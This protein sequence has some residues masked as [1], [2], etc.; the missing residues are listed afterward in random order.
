MF[1]ELKPDIYQCD[2]VLFVRPEL[3]KL[4]ERVLEKGFVKLLIQKSGSNRLP[5]QVWIEGAKSNPDKKEYGTAAVLLKYMNDRYDCRLFCRIF[6]IAIFCIQWNPS[7][8][9]TQ[10]KCLD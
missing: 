3:T 10:F 9:D 2:N 5:V 4:I 1:D 6:Y 8:S 7:K